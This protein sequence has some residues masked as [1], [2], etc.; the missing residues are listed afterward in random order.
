MIELGFLTNTLLPDTL[1][2]IA[3]K[4][5]AE[6]NLIVLSTLFK[7]WKP[8]KNKLVRLVMCDNFSKQLWSIPQ[9]LLATILLAFANVF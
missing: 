4:R 6:R 5:I 3:R 1:E 7:R 2:A 9:Y 8:T